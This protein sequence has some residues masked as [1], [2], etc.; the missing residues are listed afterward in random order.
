MLLPLSVPPFLL[1]PPPLPLLVPLSSPPVL[2]P[3][4]KTLLFTHS[5]VLLKRPGALLGR[6]FD[7]RVTG[8]RLA[9]FT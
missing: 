8:V 3:P 1:V 5:S 4:V 9:T 7:H 2:L 6:S